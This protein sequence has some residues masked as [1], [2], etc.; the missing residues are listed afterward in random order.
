M[1]LKFR[2]DIEEKGAFDDDDDYGDHG[3]G[4]QVPF[5][6]AVIIDASCVFR[7]GFAPYTVD[8]KSRLV[9]GKRNEPVKEALFRGVVWTPHIWRK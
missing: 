2:F 1:L 7:L 5:L 6:A 4:M 9:S 3:N 8:A